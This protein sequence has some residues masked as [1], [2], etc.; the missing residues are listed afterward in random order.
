MAETAARLLAVIPAR[1][2]S[3]RLPGKNVRPLAGRPLIAWSVATARNS[4][5]CECVM[6]ST[7]DAQ[8]AA[9]ARQA[10]AHVPWLRPPELATDTA[11]TSD[12][13]RHALAWYEA[14]HGRIEAVLLLQPTSPLRRTDSVREAVAMYLMQPPGQRHCVVSVSPAAP[15][16][17]WC[18]RLTAQGMEPFLGWDALSRRSQDLPPAYALNGSI[19]VIPADTVRSGEPVIGPG[20]KAFA[21]SAPYESVDIDTEADWRLAES[22]VSQLPGEGA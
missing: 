8:I 7:D 2:G 9:V 21:M 13:L 5:M 18:F 11:T 1:G 19:Y 10:G 17:A 12:V 15:H 6:V 20:A 16:P 3:K 14:E 22:L 4:G